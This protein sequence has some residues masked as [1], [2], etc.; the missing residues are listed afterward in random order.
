MRSVP[1]EIFIA[2]GFE[3]F[4]YEDSALPI[5]EGQSI[6]QPYI[7]AAMLEAAELEEGDKVLEIGAGSGYATA[8]LGRVADQ[9]FAIERHAAL[10]EAARE[11]LR[12]LGYDNVELKTADGSNGWPEAAPFDAII[13]SAGGPK[14][15]QSLKEQL[16]IGGR[17]V[18]PVGP[19]DEQRLI[20]LTRLAPDEFEEDDLGAVRFVQLIGAEGWEAPAKTSTQAP[21]RREARD[22]T[23]PEQIARAAEPL[24][25]FED[26]NFGK[27]FD[28][29]GGK[30]VVL[31]GEASHGTSEFYRAR[32]AI[33]RRLI[34]EHGFNIV[35]VEADWP[36]AAA[37]DR[38]VKGLPPRAGSE[39]PFQRFPTW[40]W[41]NRD[42]AAF[43][44]W[45]RHHNK[46]ATAPC[47]FYGLD[48]YNMRGAITAVLAYLD[49]VDPEAAQVARERYAC[50]TPWQHEPATYGRA[51]LTAG[52][53]KCEEAV[54]RQCRELLQRQLAYADGEEFLNASQNARLIASAE[55]Y[56][57]VM[58]YGGAQS[59][60]LRDSHMFDTLTRLLDWKGPRAKAVVWAHNSHIGDARHTD[61]GQ[62]RDELNIGQLCR[63]RFGDNCALIGMGTDHG[64]VA[65]ASD[66]DGEMEIKQVRPSRDDSVERQCHDSGKERFLLDFEREPGLARRLAEP[67]LERFIGVIYRPDTELRSHYAEAALSR[68]FDAYLWFDETRAVEETGPETHK[69]VPDT[70]PFGV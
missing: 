11:R 52:Y 29:F 32:A 27:L 37:I 43:T 68:Q 67:R 12:A 40:M 25:A 15:P 7:V 61:M 39:P 49:I 20:R 58:Y 65:A 36:D 1:R 18:I 24:P 23:L 41:K 66:W 31:L 55:R 10:T 30:Q 53:R 59:W 35:A 17:L 22:L 9:V 51:V 54:I 50:L 69:G 57:R 2:P 56:Y 8:L 38:H 62:V 63:Q 34:R 33:T 46:Q 21:P 3:E 13:V 45:L 48:I 16:V 14:V 28:R 26:P 4:A 42:F 5:A 64:T 47:G 19:P 60:N 70:F 44:T 6:S